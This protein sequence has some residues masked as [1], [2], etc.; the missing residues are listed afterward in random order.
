MEACIYKRFGKENVLEW[1]DGWPKPVCKSD[2]VI[3]EVAASSINPKD[4]LLRRGKFSK[5]LARDPLP[6][7]T[8]LDASG[9]VVKIGRNVTRIKV[10]DAVLGMTNNFSGGVLSTFAEFKEKEVAKVPISISL[11]DAASIPL[12][13]Q[14]AL[15]ALRDICG[16]TQGKKVLITG[17][18][19]GVG[20]FG[21]QIAIQLGAE[22][23]G[24]CSTG[25]IDFVSS[26]GAHRIYDYKKNEPAAI[27]NRYD[28]IFDAAG[29]YNRKYFSQQ[30]RKSGIFITTV[31][32]GKSLLSE[33]MARLK[34]SKKNRLVFVHSS[35]KDL[36]QLADWID[37]GKLSSHIQKVYEKNEI[38]E[39]HTQIQTGHSRGKII[40][41]L[42]SDN[43]PNNA[44]TAD[45][46]S[47]AAD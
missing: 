12:A 28:A 45:A 46:Q 18:S 32:S 35:H 3:V 37:S 39:A 31:P 13:A 43:T 10:G 9:I 24:I 44:N 16:V 25:N 26:L 6:R 33:L 29:R 2:S 22:V 4:A 23:H 36:S 11:V 1:V 8:G 15:Q 5:T 38:V 14:T 42:M 19:G 34:I 41:V 30:L 40:V 21:V 17:V 7:V 27:D 20:H 47:R